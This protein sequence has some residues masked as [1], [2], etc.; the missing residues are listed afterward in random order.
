MKGNNLILGAIIVCVYTVL[1][2]IDVHYITKEK[3]VFKKLLQEGI[4]VL[5]SYLAGLFIYNQIEPGKVLADVPGVFVTE[6]GF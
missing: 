2:Y 3:V 1:R 4:I 6:P 5:L